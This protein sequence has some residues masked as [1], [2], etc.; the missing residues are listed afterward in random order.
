MTRRIFYGR[1]VDIHRDKI[2]Y[3]IL[4]NLDHYRMLFDQKIINVTHI[5]QECKQRGQTDIH[6]IIP[7]N[8][9]GAHSVKNF[10]ELCR[11]CHVKYESGEISSTL[12]GKLCYK[13][14]KKRH[15]IL[16]KLYT[17]NLMTTS[18]LTKF[19]NKHLTIDND[20]K[21]LLRNGDNDRLNEYL[22]QCKITRN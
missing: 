11:Q 3:L 21:T 14:I 6:H 22:T 19:V 13:L 4:S 10:I 5:C 15:K 2:S 17:A 9:L 16:L 12:P 18:C 8:K 7:I 20:I 1:I